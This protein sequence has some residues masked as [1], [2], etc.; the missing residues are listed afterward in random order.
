M[1]KTAPKKTKCSKN[2]KILKVGHLVKAIAH[3]KA[4]AVAEWAFW[5]RS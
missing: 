2:E 5:V 1:Q 4:I 3:I